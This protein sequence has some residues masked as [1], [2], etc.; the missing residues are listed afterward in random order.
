VLTALGLADD[1][2]STAVRFSWTTASRDDLAHAVGALVDAVETV[3]GMG[4]TG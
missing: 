3:R 1:E 2:A 4:P